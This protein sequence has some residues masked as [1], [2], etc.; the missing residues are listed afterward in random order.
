MKQFKKNWKTTLA[1]LLAGIAVQV[2]PDVL[3]ATTAKS[4]LAIAVTI[5][6]AMA[7]DGEAQESEA[8]QRLL[9]FK[10]NQ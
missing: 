10:S 4:V 9:D 6:G 7:K 3:D 1:G 8:S 5:L 2:L